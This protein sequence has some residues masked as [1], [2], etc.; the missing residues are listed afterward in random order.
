[1]TI[2]T[3]TSFPY[4]AIAKRHGLDYGYVLQLADIG[5]HG[6]SHDWDIVLAPEPVMS[7]I[8]GAVTRFKLIQQGAL[9][10]W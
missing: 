2:K 4:L 7:E 5:V 1:M 6:R 10:P 8:L 3:T 9:K